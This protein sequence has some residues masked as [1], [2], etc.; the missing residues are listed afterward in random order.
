M[1]IVTEIKSFFGP[2]R[3][4]FMMNILILGYF[5]IANIWCWYMIP[6]APLVTHPLFLF[7]LVFFSLFGLLC[8]GLKGFAYGA[9]LIAGSVVILNGAFFPIFFI[10]W[11]LGQL[12]TFLTTIPF[13]VAGNVGNF[14]AFLLTGLAIL[15]VVLLFIISQL[16]WKKEPLS[17]EHED[18]SSPTFTGDLW[19]GRWG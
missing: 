7:P 16:Y 18:Y 1:D 8:G 14:I 5:I 3:G 10:G 19:G 17:D 12:F 11:L 2:T 15:V 13:P 4:V 6:E 9:Y